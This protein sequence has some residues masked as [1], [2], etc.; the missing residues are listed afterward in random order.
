MFCCSIPIFILLIIVIIGFIS[1][2]LSPYTN[3]G[4]ITQRPHGNLYYLGDTEGRDDLNDTDYTNPS[5]KYV[6]KPW[7]EAGGAR[8]YVKT[9]PD[10][11]MV[12]QYGDMI[13]YNGELEDELYVTDI[14]PDDGE[15]GI[16]GSHTTK[17]EPVVYN[18][19]L[20]DDLESR[21]K[22]ESFEINK[23]VSNLY[24]TGGS[25]PLRAPSDMNKMAEDRHIWYDYNMIPA[26]PTSESISRMNQEIKYISSPEYELLGSKKL[27]FPKLCDEYGNKSLAGG[28][29][30]SAVR[31]SEDN[32]EEGYG[33]LPEDN[34]LYMV[35]E[36]G[37]QRSHP[38]WNKK[39]YPRVDT[40]GI[41][42]E[43]L[44][45]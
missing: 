7:H 44:F 5:N 28:Q 2:E 25:E 17:M 31:P 33:N 26:G 12:Q 27:I 18:K 21:Y 30:P 9:K 29:E 20:Q 42:R 16:I 8:Y 36:F 40:Q 34:M 3:W 1:P 14:L 6:N 24:K 13:D 43:S 15:I 39:D 45:R 41:N 32:S 11:Q 22:K 10:G 23:L 38:A 37:V 35:E 19:T 4:S